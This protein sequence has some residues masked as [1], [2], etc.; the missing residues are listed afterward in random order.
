MLPTGTPTKAQYEALQRSAPY[1]EMEHFSDAFLAEHADALQEYAEKWS[2]D[3]FHAW[4]RGWEYCFA[5][6]RL[7]SG[8]CILDSGSGATFFPWFVANRLN[9]DV[10]CVDT[11]PIA[12]QPML[13]MTLPQAGSV[14]PCFG[15]LEDLQ[16]P[17]ATFDAVVC[18]S[19]LE[20]VSDPL[21][22]MA[23]LQRVV[24]PGGLLI[25]TWD[26]PARPGY[27]SCSGLSVC[28]AA[29]EVA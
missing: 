26:I 11:D 19:T 3:P 1:R 22:V 29:Y 13:D 17:D 10:A 24:K 12:I 28:C 5:F 16:F 25:L 20:H 4:S 2:T 18:I 27:L 23:E 21:Q 15:N 8:S 7:R 14:A 6:D 9:A